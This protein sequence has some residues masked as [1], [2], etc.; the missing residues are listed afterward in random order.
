VK[1]AVALPTEMIFP[2]QLAAL[3]GLV[4]DGGLVDFAPWTREFGDR[5][6]VLLPHFHVRVHR[7]YLGGEDEFLSQLVNSLGW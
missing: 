4:G 7:Y 1:R 3:C 6:A 5:L 2:S